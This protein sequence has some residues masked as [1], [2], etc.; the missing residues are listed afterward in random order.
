MTCDSSSLEGMPIY[1]FRVQSAKYSCMYVYNRIQ[2]FIVEFREFVAKL[3]D[4]EFQQY[5]DAV[6]DRKLQPDSHMHQETGRHWSEIKNRRYDF[7]YLEL[8]VAVLR[9]VSKADVLAM[10]D[11]VLMPEH[12]REL[13]IFIDAGAGKDSDAE[14]AATS[15]PPTVLLDAAA[16]LGAWRRSMPH[17]RRAVGDP[18]EYRA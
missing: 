16:D 7:R 12:R 9:E 15:E 17:F 8:E 5:V 13:A 4:K 3:T 10:Y 14:A 18:S 1:Y 11:T 6:I 2:G